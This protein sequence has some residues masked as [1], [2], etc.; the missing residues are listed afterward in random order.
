MLPFFFILKKLGV[1]RVPLEVEMA[2]MDASEHAG[3]MYCLLGGFAVA[4]SHPGPVTEPCSSPSFFSRLFV[5]SLQVL[6]SSAAKRPKAA[7]P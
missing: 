7:P 6:T 4:F 2:G 3:G 5:L 1:F